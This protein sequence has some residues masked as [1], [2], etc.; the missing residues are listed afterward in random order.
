MKVTL[1]PCSMTIF[2]TSDTHF[3]HKRIIE[4]AKRP[5]NDLDHMHIELIR[6]WNSVVRPQDTIFHLGDVSFGRS[7]ETWDL[8][9]EL[10]GHKNLILGNHDKPRRAENAAWEFITPYREIRDSG[11]HVVLCHYAM[12]VWNRHHHGALMLYGHSH[13]NLPGDSQSLDVGVDC[14]DYTPVTLDQIQQRMTTLPSHKF[15][16][17]HQPVAP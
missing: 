6:R 1:L 8:L 15:P 11:R 14:W 3:F 5:F 10:N 4:M 17:H 16:D 12:R 13:G 2:Y 7:N 9:G